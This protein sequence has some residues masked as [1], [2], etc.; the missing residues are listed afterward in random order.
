MNIF[1]LCTIR[2]PELRKFGLMVFETLRIGFPTAS[3]TVDMNNLSEDDETAVMQS[4]GRVN[5]VARTTKTIHHIWIEK[6]LADEHDPFWIVDTD[7]IFYANFEQF[8]CE[9]KSPLCGW[10]IPEFNDSFSGCITRARLHTS[11]LRIDPVRV[12]QAIKEYESQIADTPFTPKANL[13]YPLVVPFKGKRYFYDTCSMVY[14]SIGGQQFED[15]HKMAFSHLHFGTIPDVV[16]PRLPQAEASQMEQ[17]R[18]CVV[19]NPSWGK[20]AWRIQEAWYASH[21]A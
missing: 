8:D 19:S 20:G 2:K 6:L 18:Q 5:A 15:R 17:A 14:N 1:V 12:R 13:I 21:P 4:C 7:I 11:L 9:F 10:R 3:V 16:L